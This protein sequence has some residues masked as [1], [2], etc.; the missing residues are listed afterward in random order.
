[1]RMFHLMADPDDRAAEAAA[2]LCAEEESEANKAAA[3]AKKKAQAKQRKAKK[4]AAAEVT[5]EEPADGE[6]TEQADQKAAQHSSTGQEAL[7]EETQSDAANDALESSSQ[8]DRDAADA[9]SGAQPLHS[10]AHGQQDSHKGGHPF[11]TC[12]TPANSFRANAVVRLRKQDTGWFGLCLWHSGE[13][14]CAAP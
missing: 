4:K 7:Q 11:W 13:N 5:A 1:M 14:T 3:K 12:V 6:V 2:L 10:G 9:L 8:L